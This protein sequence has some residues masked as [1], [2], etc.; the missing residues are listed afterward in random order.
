MPRNWRARLE[1]VGLKV[2][3]VPGV[4]L[5]LEAGDY[6]MVNV[7][8]AGAMSYFLPVDLERLKEAAEAQVPKGTY[9]KNLQALLLGREAAATASS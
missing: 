3:E 2:V 8:M 6:R 5:A 7:V 4:K 1:R 9:G